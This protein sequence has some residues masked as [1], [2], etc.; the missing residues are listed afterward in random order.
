MFVPPAPSRSAGRR[1]A[2][3]QATRKSPGGVPPG[4]SGPEKTAGLDLRAFLIQYGPRGM[5]RQS[6]CGVL[7][8]RAKKLRSRVRHPLGPYPKRTR[9]SS[10][11]VLTAALRWRCIDPARK[12]FRNGWSKSE[13]EPTSD[14]PIYYGPGH[15][16]PAFRGIGHIF[17][18][19]PS[20]KKKPQVDR[21]S[22]EETIHLIMIR[23]GNVSD[24][25]HSPENRSPRGGLLG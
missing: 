22:R 19:R 14:R 15:P 20:L 16:V 13:H 3:L 8:S 10:F 24:I 18:Q 11:P 12:W 25:S 9:W 5:Y 7:L 2:G 21:G 4:L 23:D 6:I 17:S 1:A